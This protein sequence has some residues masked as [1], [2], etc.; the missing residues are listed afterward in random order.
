MARYPEDRYESY[1]AF[2]EQLEDAK[3]R[4]TDPTFRERQ[5]EA[6]VIV[7]APETAKSNLWLIIAMVA[8]VVIVVG[9]LAWKGSSLLHLGQNVPPELSGYTPK[10]A[11]A[12]PAA[13]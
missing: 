4:I 2:I 5:N 7:A 1:A 9:L 6:V 3:R 13:H 8:I 11:S 10:G 12:T